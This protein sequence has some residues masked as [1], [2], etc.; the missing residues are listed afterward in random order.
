MSLR[1]PGAGGMVVFALAMA[2]A[3]DHGQQRVGLGL[4]MP[5]TTLLLPPHLLLLLFPTRQHHCQSLRALTA[6]PERIRG[7]FK[8]VVPKVQECFP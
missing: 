3:P 7:R 6:D 2:I 8:E 4:L 1:I 5:L